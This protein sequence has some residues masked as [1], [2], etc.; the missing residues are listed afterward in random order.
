MIEVIKSGRSKSRFNIFVDDLRIGAVIRGEN[1][2]QWERI[3]GNIG[4]T[5]KLRRDAIAALQAV[6]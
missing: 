4:G 2:W 3:G 1:K 5:C 6:A